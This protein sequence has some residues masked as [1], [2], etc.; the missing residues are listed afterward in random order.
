MKDNATV[1]TANNSIAALDEVVAEKSL[2]EDC[3]LRD[4]PTEILV[5]FTYGSR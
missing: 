1:H 3:G 2:V 5:T 4:H